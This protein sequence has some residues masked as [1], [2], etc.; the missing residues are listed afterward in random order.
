[1]VRTGASS[2]L[3]FDLNRFSRLRQRSEHCQGRRS[4]QENAATC[5]DAFFDS[6]ASCLKCVLDAVL[7]L[8]ELN[9]GSCAN[10]DT[11]PPAKL[12]KTLLEL[13]GRSQVVISISAL[14]WALVDCLLGTSATNI[15]SGLL[16]DLDGLNAT[17]AS[18]R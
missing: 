13:R 16:S 17:R 3:R 1:M 5:D 18:L 8:L 15:G 10:L 7:D 2:A 6:C 11:T 14:I 9:L 4:S 12:S